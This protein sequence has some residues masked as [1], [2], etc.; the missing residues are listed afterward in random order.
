MSREEKEK[1]REERDRMMAEERR[2]AGR[3]RDEH[4]AEVCHHQLESERCYD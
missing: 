1:A 3:M 4:F 2:A